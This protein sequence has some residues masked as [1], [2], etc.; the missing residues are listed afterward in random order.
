MLLLLLLVNYYSHSFDSGPKGTFSYSR[1]KYI[2]VGE[3]NT[4]THFPQQGAVF[5]KFMLILCPAPKK[6][7]N[8]VPQ[9]WKLKFKKRIQDWLSLLRLFLLYYTGRPCVN[10]PRVSSP[11]GAPPC[12]SWVST[13]KPFILPVLLKYHLYNKRNAVQLQDCYEIKLDIITALG[14]MRQVLNSADNTAF[15]FTC[16]TQRESLK[17]PPKRGQD[18]LVWKTWNHKSIKFWSTIYWYYVSLNKML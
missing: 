14:M 4:T 2:K 8:S 17:E 1:S 12:V 6:G 15:L 3:T 11:V 16:I 7:S 18:V 5:C 10:R 9:M 13:G